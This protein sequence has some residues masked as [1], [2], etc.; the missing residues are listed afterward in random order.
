[1]RHRLNRVTL[2]A[3]TKVGLLAAFLV[4]VSSPAA[5]LTLGQELV[6]NGGFEADANIAQPSGWTFTAAPSDSRAAAV[7]VEAHGG[8]NSYF[9]GSGGNYDKLSQVIATDPFAEYQVQAWVKVDNFLDPGSLS[10]SLLAAFGPYNVFLVQGTDNFEY[11]LL[12]KTIFATSASTELNFFGANKGG[13]FYVDDVSVRKVL[14]AVPEPSTWAMMIMG[15]GAV[16]AMTRRS[17]RTQSSAP[18]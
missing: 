16:G 2:G 8:F 3:A 18:A 14:S 15:F 5:A 4:A 9:F 17:R 12:T 6:V 7:A 1:M 11:M 10:N 13:N